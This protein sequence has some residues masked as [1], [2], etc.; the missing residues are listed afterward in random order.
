MKDP[1]HCNFTALEKNSLQSRVWSIFQLK[2]F[3]LIFQPELFIWGDATFLKKF[4]LTSWEM[5]T[6]CAWSF[7]TF[8]LTAIRVLFERRPDQNV[9]CSPF[10]CDSSSFLPEKHPQF[11]FSS[12]NV[13]A[14]SGGKERALFEYRIELLSFAQYSS[15]AQ[16][17]D[18]QE[19]ALCHC[20][21]TDHE[22]LVQAMSILDL[23]RFSTEKQSPRSFVVFFSATDRGRCLLPVCACSHG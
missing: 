5:P 10:C 23:S 1:L 7:E 22:I 13:T 17:H 6:R 8:C 2:N 21:S 16:L 18:K 15:P 12:K 20:Q 4:A 14:E 11:F 9:L 19:S 3:P